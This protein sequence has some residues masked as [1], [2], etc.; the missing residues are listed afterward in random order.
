MYQAVMS[1]HHLSNGSG[2]AGLEL[3]GHQLDPPG[4]HHE[5][6]PEEEVRAQGQ[7]Q[8]PHNQSACRDR[9]IQRD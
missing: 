2:E 3:R 4:H 9:V 8:G 1:C 6:K 5:Q 7:G